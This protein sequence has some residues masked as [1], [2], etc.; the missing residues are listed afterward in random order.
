MDFGQTSLRKTATYTFDIQRIGII[1]PRWLELMWLLL[2]HIQQTLTISNLGGLIYILSLGE[3][4]CSFPFKYGGDHF[5][6]DNLEWEITK[7]ISLLDCHLIGSLEN[8]AIPSQ[9]EWLWKDCIK[10]KCLFIWNYSQV[11]MGEFFFK[12]LFARVSIDHSL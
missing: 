5:F 8:R 3:Q 6:P 9:Y 4:Y 11:D 12:C 10:A 2:M 7:W 1:L